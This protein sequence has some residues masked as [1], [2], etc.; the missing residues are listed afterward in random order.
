MVRKVRRLV[1][2]AGTE[3]RRIS[4]NMMP[5]VLTRF[6]LKAAL[7][8]L[9]EDFS[10]KT[11]TEVHMGITL[12]ERLHDNKEFMIFRMAQEL[13]HNTLKHSKADKV[14]FL[15]RRQGETVFVD[16]RDN[17]MGFNL[18]KSGKSDGIGLQSIRSRVEFLHGTFYLQTSPGNGFKLKITF[19]VL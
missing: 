14:T 9:F 3:V 6:G 13:L 7:E 17:G 8:D 1:E 19:P 4:H 5:E 15:L 12:P 2:Q 10:E 16:Y 18:E 11:K